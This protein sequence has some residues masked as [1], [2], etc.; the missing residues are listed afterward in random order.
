MMPT[1]ASLHARWTRR[2]TFSSLAINGTFCLW[3]AIRVYGY[4]PRGNVLTFFL[5]DRRQEIWGDAEV[6]FLPLPG[7]PSGHPPEGWVG[8]GLERACPGLD[9]G[10][11]VRGNRQ[12]HVGDIRLSPGCVIIGSIQKVSL[13]GGH[14]ADEAI[15]CHYGIARL[16]RSNPGF[17]E[18][19]PDY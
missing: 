17:Q 13:R 1:T 11:G 8:M 12:A 18:I 9:P 2:R 16:C 19:A 14:K 15:S 10:V 5:K 3:G 7:N 4:L 6:L